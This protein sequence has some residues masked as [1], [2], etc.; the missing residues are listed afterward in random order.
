MKYKIKENNTILRKSDGTWIPKDSGNSDYQKFLADVKEQGLGIVEGPDIVTPDYKT[1]RQNEYPHIREQLD[2][3]YWDLKNGRL[4]TGDWIQNITK[5][6]LK[7]SKSNTGTTTIGELPQ[8]V[9]TEGTG[10]F[11]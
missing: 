4:D 9:I 10:N 5:I 7:H 8:W 6:K 1:A 2:Q 3:L 11:P